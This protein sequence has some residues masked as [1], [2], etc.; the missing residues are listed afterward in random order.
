MHCCSTSIV[1]CTFFA[2][3]FFSSCLLKTW[4]CSNPDNKDERK[5]AHGIH[6]PTPAIISVAAT[7][8]TTSACGADTNLVTTVLSGFLH[9][10]VRF[11]TLYLSFSISSLCLL[12]STPTT[13]IGR[14]STTASPTKKAGGHAIKNAVHSFLL[15]LSSGNV[16]SSSFWS[17]YSAPFNLIFQTLFS[18]LPT[19]Y[20]H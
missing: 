19:I 10:K 4:A 9:M 16:S 5:I 17:A 20:S 13:R 2:A 1:L 12:A 7:C 18:S 6:F 11:G 15:I 14:V 3:F 8:V